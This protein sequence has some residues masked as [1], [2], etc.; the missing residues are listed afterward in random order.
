[1]ELNRMR[2]L[3]LILS[4]LVI[5]IIGIRVFRS[6]QHT[7]H[8]KESALLVGTS[9]DYPPF[10][11]L[12]DGNI[13]GFD[14]DV[15]KAVAE[16]LHKKIEIKDIPFDMLIPEIQLGK[17]H[18][19]AA[20]MTQTPARAERVLFTRP[21][22]QG[23]KLLVLSPK[24]KPAIRSLEDLTNKEV[25]VNDGYTADLYMSKLKGPIIKRLKTPAEA[26]LA[27]TTNK[28]DAYV[29]ASNTAQPF[30]K[31][32]GSEQFNIYPLPEATDS[33]SFAI[34]KKYPELLEPIQKAVDDL[35]AD[36]TLAQLKQKWNLQ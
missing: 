26:F 20:G 13:V 32:Y 2:K 4:I 10:S 21:Y 12:K 30:F 27:L 18:L 9:A 19:I 31:L 5:A 24:N 34:S 3:Y 22:I 16:R 15:I 14:I 25:L 1:M 23:D 6:L 7:S 11:F 17:I 29:V 35:E 28:A 8:L 36:G 33:Y